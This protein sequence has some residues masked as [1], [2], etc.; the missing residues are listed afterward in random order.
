MFRVYHA[1]LLKLILVLLDNKA[2]IL[3]LMVEGG[4]IFLLIIFKIAGGS[5]LGWSGSQKKSVES[6]IR[7][8]EFLG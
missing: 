3:L 8:R 5:F 2:S 4:R 1:E 7:N 6:R